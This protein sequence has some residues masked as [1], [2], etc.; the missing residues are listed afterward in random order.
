[1]PTVANLQPAPA[2]LAGEEPIA[3]VTDA[4]GD[5]RRYW[6]FISYSHTDEVYARW[7]HRSIERF[8][9]HAKLAGSTG[10]HGE[11]VPERVQP[12]FRDREELEGAADLGSRIAEALG[13]SRCLI[14]IC[15]PRA[16]T[17]RYV[18]NEIRH[19][20]ALGREH[21]VL[22]LI[23][24]GE[25]G[26]AA[27][28]LPATQECFPPALTQSFD[29]QGALIGT[30]AEPLA[31]D[32]RAGKDDR[33]DALL[34]LLAGV[35]GLALDDLRRRDAQRRLRVRS[36]LTALA[37]GLSGVFLALALLA[38]EARKEAELQQQIALARQLAA[39]AE[40]ARAEP[41]RIAESLGD[42]L[43]A[44]D[45]LAARG[46]RSFDV[47]AALRRSLALSPRAF[48]AT[49][50]LPAD[51]SAL[52]SVPG[53][54]LITMHEHTDAMVHTPA[55][56]PTSAA[57]A[58]VA[59]AVAPEPA[60]K[61]RSYALAAG[62]TVLPPQRWPGHWR[63]AGV[64]RQEH[65]QSEGDGR[66]WLGAG[67]DGRRM[68]LDVVSGHM[69]PMPQG[70]DPVLAIDDAGQRV[71]LAAPEA[72]IVHTLG[73]GA[74]PPL[75]LPHPRDGLPREGTA[76]TVTA[77]RAAFAPDNGRLAVGYTLHIGRQ[78][79]LGSV[80][81][82]PLVADGS[83][84]AP[85]APAEFWLT[86]QS[87][88]WL[89][90][91]SKDELLWGGWRT[92]NLRRELQSQ[93]LPSPG[94][95]GMVAVDENGSLI[96][97][98]DSQGTVR[99]WDIGASAAASE[100]WRVALPG[101]L[102]SLRFIGREGLL[103]AVDSGGRVSLWRSE[104]EG[105]LQV[106]LPPRPPQPAPG[107]SARAHRASR[108]LWIDPDEHWLVTV[109]HDVAREREAAATGGAAQNPPGPLSRY[110]ATLQA[111]HAADG[112]PL[113]QALT[114]NATVQHARVSADGRWLLAAQNQPQARL[115]WF[116]LTSGR[117]AAEI[118]LG[119]SRIEQMRLAADG[120][121]VLYRLANRTLWSWH[122]AQAQQVPQQLAETTAFAW[123][124]SSQRLAVVR[125]NEVH[126]LN[127][128]TLQALR[129]PLP[130]GARQLAWATGGEHLALQDDEGVVWVW[131]A[132]RGERL[133]LIEG[134]PFGGELHFTRRGNW[135]G[136]TDANGRRSH[137]PWGL[138][139]L[140]KEGCARW[141][142]V[143]AAQGMH[144]PST[145]SAPDATSQPGT[146]HKRILPV[147]QTQ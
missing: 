46:E 32:L 66:W 22:A 34:K 141:Q 74:P 12:V 84:S 80:A 9:G 127:A 124:E 18:N 142:A 111:F 57:P 6:A 68:L 73:A 93:S 69:Q 107:A 42:A 50:Q 17:S 26:A 45:L 30:S 94:D 28:S 98:A 106:L 133:G 136:V 27:R 116:D 79:P 134:L 72:V 33:R 121:R 76:N 99:L 119:G 147:C 37:L 15:S 103:A 47:D 112:R 49:V 95:K 135:L 101:P 86:D 55:A 16:A 48:A 64:D 120:Q 70:E 91:P 25:P 13:A 104:G 140:L 59:T 7:L 77:S 129:P 10:R 21:R 56:S 39:Q 5:G 100:R 65:S 35:L 63:P 8:R 118:K 96:S 113:G 88:S 53:D 108:V 40:L 115:L 110:V 123:D 132:E 38:N 75:V 105:A 43:R 4:S 97:T 137:S 36:A 3:A 92:L 122:P 51:A 41:R 24:D 126:L 102:R 1:M 20:K 143:A 19:F 14:V 145:K 62:E 11:V 78:V 125:E 109:T 146:A 138:P 89:H 87:I 2:M 58:A 71:A 61:R 90:W 29:A 139:V 83:R 67:E 44:I 144:T 60:L 128:Q 131:N 82:W 85:A 130:T 54:L 117:L 52:V 81:L 114:S 23:V 31:A